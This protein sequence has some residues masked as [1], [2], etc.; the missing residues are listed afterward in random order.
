MKA[1]IA[2]IP[3]VALHI[4]IPVDLDTRLRELARREQ[5]TV[6]VT[7]E[8]ILRRYL[9]RFRLDGSAE[10]ETPDREEVSEPAAERATRGAR[11]DE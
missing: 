6:T 9:F 3:R 5:R 4:W 11:G 1:E 2:K 10:Y 7:A 8:R